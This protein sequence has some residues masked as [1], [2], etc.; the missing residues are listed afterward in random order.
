MRR[1]LGLNLASA[2]TR[3]NCFDLH[4]GADEMHRWQTD[5]PRRVAI[6]DFPARINQHRMIRSTTS[7]GTQLFNRGRLI[8]SILS[9]QGNH[10]Q[11]F[12]FKLLVPGFQPGC[13]SEAG[14][15]PEG[16]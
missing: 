16:R 5:G 13:L 6:G 11:A 3:L 7:P 14:A 8:G 1:E 2:E 10:H 9:H 12:V 4:A 15:S